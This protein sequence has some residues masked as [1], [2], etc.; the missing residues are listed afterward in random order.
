MRGK[1]YFTQRTSNQTI[2]R[3]GSMF[4]RYDG[5]EFFSLNTWTSVDLNLW[6]LS[7]LFS[8]KMASKHRKKSHILG[9]VGKGSDSSYHGGFS[10]TWKKG[11]SFCP[12][13][14]GGSACLFL[15]AI[16]R[17]HPNAAVSKHFIIRLIKLPCHTF[18][19]GLLVSEP[20]K[21][22]RSYIQIFVGAPRTCLGFCTLIAV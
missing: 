6:A 17:Q 11:K 20:L 12:Q 4:A 14:M 3:D 16:F 18:L 22:D 15:P 8:W 7:I 5:F 13:D 21:E 1:Q 10:P 9:E 19:C 2:G